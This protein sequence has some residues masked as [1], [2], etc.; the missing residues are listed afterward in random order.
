MTQ[1]FALCT[2]IAIIATAGMLVFF[3][4][5]RL[6]GILKIDIVRAVGS[7]VTQ[8][9]DNALIPGLIFYLIHGLLACYA[10][11]LIFQVLPV[12][13]IK[14]NIVFAALG[15][16]LGFN[17][18]MIAALILGML[19]SVHPIEKLRDDRFAIAALNSAAQIIFGCI[20]GSLYS[21]I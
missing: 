7:L 2:L 18:G 16:G 8:K 10:Y 13:A 1:I 21:L 11:I 3:W 15:M 5:L 4:G 9:Q 6:T 14:H 20:V 17:H 19:L 12:A